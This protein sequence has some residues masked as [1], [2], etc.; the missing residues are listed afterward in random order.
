MERKRLR[1]SVQ[2]EDL[3]VVLFAKHHKKVVTMPI[4][5]DLSG[6]ECPECSSE[7]IFSEYPAETGV[8]SELGFICESS[9]KC[10]YDE[11]PDTYNQRLE[12]EW[13]SNYKEE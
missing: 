7:L 11:E 9:D 2:I 4:G 8:E 10:K 13:E 6:I 1:R 5:G 12:P 3:T